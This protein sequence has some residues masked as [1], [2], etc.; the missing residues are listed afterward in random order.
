MVD[1]EKRREA[2]IFFYFFF[3]FNICR[4]GFRRGPCLRK[5]VKCDLYLTK[6]GQLDG[7]RDQ[8]GAIG[9]GSSSLLISSVISQYNTTQFVSDLVFLNNFENLQTSELQFSV[10]EPMI[11]NDHL[12]TSFFNLAN[13]LKELVKITQKTTENVFCT[14]LS[15]KITYSILFLIFK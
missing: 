7:Y 10:C 2:A 3:F 6:Q 12:L 14:G 4:G 5:M 8:F 13:Y 11:W 1:R 9:F 15:M